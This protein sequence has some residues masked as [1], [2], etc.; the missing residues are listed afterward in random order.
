MGTGV[1]GINKTGI[2]LES[3]H[4]LGK[5]TLGI[6]VRGFLKWLKGYVHTKT[7]VL[8]TNYLK[9]EGESFSERVKRLCASTFLDTDCLKLD[10]DYF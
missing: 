9:L 4:V 6:R 5:T 7:H 8:E 2:I 10:W 1:L 3:T